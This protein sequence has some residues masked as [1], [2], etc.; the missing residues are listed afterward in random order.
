METVSKFLA[1]AVGGAFGASARYL[2]NQI[3]AGFFPAFPFA[4]FLINITGSFVL[5][6][7]LTL[8]ADR[9]VVSDYWRLFFAVGFLGAY[10][11]F[12]T[13][14]FETFEFARERDFLNALLYILLS[15]IVGFV[16]V[17]AGVWLAKRF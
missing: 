12:S 14:E 7:F 4:T 15:L 11:T 3:L 6:F 5:G 2:L 1:V 9:F 10:T 13:F 8:T 16:S 17:A